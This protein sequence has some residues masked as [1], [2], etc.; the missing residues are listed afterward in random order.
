MSKEEHIHKFMRLGKS[1]SGK[2]RYRCVLPDCYFVVNKELLLGKQSLCN[3]CSA[4]II[5]DRYDLTRAAP[6]CI[7]C[8]KTKEAVKF[9]QAA[10]VA[11]KL[12]G[13][14][15]DDGEVKHG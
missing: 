3:E 13:V 5:L 6:R 10:D 14:L 11:S 2:V 7:N 1:R 4:P 8:K 15:G 9:K 12:F